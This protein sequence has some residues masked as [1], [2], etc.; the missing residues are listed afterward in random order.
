M[1]RKVLKKK[2]I[3]QKQKQSQNVIV[4]L[5]MAKH[6]ARRKPS[7]KRM[8]PVIYQPPIRMIQSYGDVL[9]R[10]PPQQQILGEDIRKIIQQEVKTPVSEL[11]EEFLSRVESKPKE[12]MIPITP[13]YDF[14]TGFDEP[15][16]VAKLEPIRERSERSERSETSEMT[17]DMF[18]PRYDGA[19]LEMLLIGDYGFTKSGRKRT[20]PTISQK[21][22]LRT[23]GKL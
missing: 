23:K 22:I 6:Y 21:A 16:P 8:Q 20:T 12:K 3:T 13:V 4:N 17:E 19:T 5:V 11:R 14:T 2:P 9:A 1:P 10:Q 18:T 7:G 15:E